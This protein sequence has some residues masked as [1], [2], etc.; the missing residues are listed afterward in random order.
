MEIYFL[1]R[2]G[3]SVK[4]SSFT[5]SA[6]NFCGTTLT[7]IFSF[8]GSIEVVVKSVGRSSFISS[9]VDVI[10]F[11]AAPSPGLSSLLIEC[12]VA[13]ARK[14]LSQKAQPQREFLF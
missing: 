5:F 3:C 1:F 13:G 4:F 8:G 7:A 9:F 11:S 12:C 10:V 2:S 6:I 14:L